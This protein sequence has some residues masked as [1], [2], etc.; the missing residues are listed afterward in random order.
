MSAKDDNVTVNFP[1]FVQM[2][3]LIWLHKLI[4]VIVPLTCFILGLLFIK[5]FTRP[6]YKTSTW[7]KL[8]LICDKTAVT[9]AIQTA[10]GDIFSG[11]Y[12]ELGIDNSVITVEAS[13]TNS[14]NVIEIVYRGNDPEIIG[15]F[16]SLYEAKYVESL[17]PIVNQSIIKNLESFDLE[18][19][20]NIKSFN[21]VTIVK[22]GKVPLDDVSKK[23][24]LSLLV[25]G[26]VFIFVLTCTSIIF[27]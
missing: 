21:Q 18:Q 17:D 14:S 2:L 15:K 5:F 16:A 1:N 23:H 11:V 22:T 13:G 8:P 10:N 26:T 6:V 24:K 20:E 4:V 9:T 3:R 27:G 25:K 7:I 12:D 19:F